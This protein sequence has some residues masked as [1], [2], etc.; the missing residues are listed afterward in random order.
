MH[1]Q[2]SEKITDTE[3]LMAALSLDPPLNVQLFEA[4]LKPELERK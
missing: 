4:D 2:E 1:Y 3:E